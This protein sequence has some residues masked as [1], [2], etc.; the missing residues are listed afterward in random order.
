MVKMMFVL[1]KACH[2]FYTMPSFVGNKINMGLRR[3]N[4]KCVELFKHCYEPAKR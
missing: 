3:T 4:V 2:G 1:L